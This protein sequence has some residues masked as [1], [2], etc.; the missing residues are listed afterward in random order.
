MNE[1]GLDPGL[2]HM[3]A[4]KIIDDINAR[5][6]TVRSFQSV[7]GGL[8]APEAANNPLK[9]KFSW[10]PKGV[11]SASQNAAQYRWKGDMVNVDGKDLMHSSMPFTDAWP[12][13]GLECLPNRDSLKYESI[14]GL[15][16]HTETLFRGTLRFEGFCSL[17][18]VFQRM[19]LFENSSTGGQSWR[20]A[21]AALSRQRGS[22][23]S[24]DAFLLDCAGGDQEKAKKAKEALHWLEMEGSNLLTNPESFVYSFSAVLEKQLQF[25]DDERDMVA[26]HT[27]IKASFEDRTSKIV[28]RHQSSLMVYGDSS[29][30]AMC[31]TVGFPAA[32]A[33]NLLLSGDLAG[34][35]GLVLPTDKRIYLPILA[36]VEKEGISF[37][38]RVEIVS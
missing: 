2:D 7:C 36:A 3:S 33:A 6:G 20:G 29:M 17:M 23:E 28:E 5:G 38:E 27:A 10:S 32:A 11:I 18:S 35:R 8:P 37:D 34:S 1:V 14:Y 19:G 30:S 21:L 22:F 13:L 31:R 12:E 9:Y 24:L 25:G 16:N 4:M 15:D 26:M